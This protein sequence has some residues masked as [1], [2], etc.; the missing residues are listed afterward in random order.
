MNKTILLAATVLTAAVSCFASGSRVGFKDA[1]AEGRA[2]AYAAT[3][4]N[5]SAVYYDGAGLTLLNGSEI[6]IGTYEVSLHSD[7]SGAAGT[8]SLARGYKSVPDFFYGSHAPDSKWA[9]GLGVFSPFGL[10]TNWAT[11]SVLSTLATANRL[12]DKTAS[13]VVAY[14]LDP[15]FSVSVGLDYSWASLGFNRHIG[16]FTPNDNLNVTA[17]GHALSYSL[18]ALWQPSP[19]HSFGLSYQSVASVNYSGT[20]TIYPL[21]SGVATTFKLAFPEVVI[22]GYSYRPTPEWNFEAD[23]D[24]TGWSRL[25]AVTAT[26]SLGPIPLNFSWKNSAFYEVGVTRYFSN[27][28]HASVGYLFTENSVPDAAYNPAV[29]DGD[30]GFYGFGVGYKDKSYFVD[31]AYHHAAGSRTVHG[32]APSL[33]GATADGSYKNSLDGFALTVGYRF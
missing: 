28:F 15:T 29:P 24:W 20:T 13:A 33:V 5:A 23:I 17:S 1:F 16:A 8:A 3:A 25:G 32:S 2:N 10:E 21:D 7:Y 31:F 9:Y 27:G 6:D 12:T 4:D 19:Q 11:T 22:A 26:S 14:K 18:G 30:K